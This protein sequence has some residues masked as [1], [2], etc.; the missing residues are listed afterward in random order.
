MA[1]SKPSDV[2]IAN[3]HVCLQSLACATLSIL[4]Q[5]YYFGNGT[6]VFHIPIVLRYF[7]DPTFRNDVYIQSLR[8]YTSEIYPVMAQVA[9]FTGAFPIFLFMHVLSRWLLYVS[10]ALAARNLGLRSIPGQW[11]LGL[12]IADRVSR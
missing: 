2:F 10:V 11:I 6:N 4:L 9:T 8:S 1:F 5:G 12:A 7:D 3:V